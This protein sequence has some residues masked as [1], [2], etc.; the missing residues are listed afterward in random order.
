[1]PYKII[2]KNG[3]FYVKTKSGPHRGRLHSKRPLEKEMAE[4]Q[5]R[6]L[7]AAES[8]NNYKKKKNLNKVY[9]GDEELINREEENALTTPLYNFSDLTTATS[10][11]ELPLYKKLT[12]KS[13]LAAK[14]SIL[15]KKKRSLF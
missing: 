6:A 11:E 2:E 10:F 3:G 7:Y 5:I 9:G 14:K 1:M 12:K 8:K 13:K 4:R 15:L